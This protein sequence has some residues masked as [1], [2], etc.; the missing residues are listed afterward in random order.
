VQLGAVILAV[1]VVIGGC[2]GDGSGTGGPSGLGLADVQLHLPAGVTDGIALVT[3]TGGTVQSVQSAGPE[4]RVA[5]AGTSTVQIIGRGN[6]S[7]GQASLATIC[8]DR[9]Q[10]LADYHVD[11]NQVAGGRTSGYA[12]RDVAGYSATLGNPRATASCP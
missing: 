12:V 7:G 10:S 2:G 11:V 9:I 3:V 5:G 8:V 4:F 1:Q 6:F